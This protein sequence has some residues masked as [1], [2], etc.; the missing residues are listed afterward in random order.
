MAFVSKEKLFSRKWFISYSLI[1]LGALIMASGY[2]LFISPN[3]IVPGG[4][5]GIGI[6]LHHL[7]GI[8]VGLTGLALNIPLTIIGIRVLGP[9]FGIKTVIGFVLTSLF[10]D[11]LTLLWGEEPLVPNEMLLSSIFGGVMIGFGLGLIFKS[12][13]TSGGSDIIAMI[14]TKYTRMPV[15]QTLIMVDSVI[16]LIGLVAF[17]DWTIPLY[18]WIVIYI[19]GKVIDGVI[20]GVSYEK[21]LFIISEKYKEIAD[22]ILIDLNRGGTYLEGKGM[23]KE[24][25][26]KVIFVNVNR[27]EVIILQDY[28]NSIDPNAFVTVINASEILGKGF[29]SLNEKVT[30]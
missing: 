28:I 12:R 13:A 7:I 24:D 6:V 23:F 15:G 30:Q 19:T 22:K 4:V 20:E 21:T 25:E 1:T 5:Y 2:V 18:S 16:V 10:I 26:K 17:G 9:R 29:R 11:G 8:P 27:R 3:K 14:V